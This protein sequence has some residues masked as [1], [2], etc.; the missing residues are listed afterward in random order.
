[1]NPDVILYARISSNSQELESQIYALN[2]YATDNTLNV[3]RRKYEIASARDAVNLKIL[4]SLIGGYTDVTIIVYSI[5]RLSRC[6]PDGYALIQLLTRRRINVIS[7]SESINLFGDTS[8]KTDFMNVVTRAENESIL[9]STRVRRS[10]DFRVYKGDH[11]GPVPYGY[12][13]VEVSAL[14]GSEFD[15][16]QNE[17]LED[18]WPEIPFLRPSEP[19]STNIDMY[20]YTK[21]SKMYNIKEQKIIKFIKCVLDK[22]MSARDMSRLLYDAVFEDHEINFKALDSDTEDYTGSNTLFTYVNA[23]SANKIAKNKKIYITSC[24]IAD[25]LNEYGY[26]KRNIMWTASSI[27]RMANRD[28]VKFRDML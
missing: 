2:K 11:I 13:I 7:T 1:M 9:I 14:K 6:V 18:T 22:K 28:Q 19:T 10:L 15:D 27:E 23:Q 5:D 26:T 3:V 4:Y 21:K 24:N 25:I 12:M 20:Y 17:I 8:G 16:F